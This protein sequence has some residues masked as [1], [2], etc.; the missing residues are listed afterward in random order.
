MEERKL[1]DKMKSRN[2]STLQLHRVLSEI[3]IDIPKR[4]LQYYLDS[5]MLKCSDDRIE[6]VA[7]F[8]IKSMDKIVLNLKT[9][10]D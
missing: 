7:N 1:Y 8:L 5:N 6:K 4:T 3:G 9:V 2:I 10:I